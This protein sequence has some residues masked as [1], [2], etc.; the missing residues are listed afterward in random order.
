[1][2]SKTFTSSQILC[3]Q[4]LWARGRRLRQSTMASGGWVDGCQASPR[5]RSL[6]IFDVAKKNVWRE[7]YKKA[8]EQLALIGNP[9]LATTGRTS[10]GARAHEGMCH[11]TPSQRA[12]LSLHRQLEAGRLED[13][14]PPPR[15]NS[16]VPTTPAVRLPLVCSHPRASIVRIV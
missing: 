7:E 3:F 16:V 5:E 1:M 10:S 11:T 15:G 8:K 13:L 12:V 6:E 2:C 9:Q 14:C 4:K